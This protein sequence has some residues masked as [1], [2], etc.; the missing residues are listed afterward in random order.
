[1]AE[2]NWEDSILTGIT[3][4]NR[5]ITER[6]S[7]WL[8]EEGADVYSNYDLPLKLRPNGILGMVVMSM[9]EID[10]DVL[11]TSLNGHF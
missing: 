7:G 3:P 6:I 9:M 11:E 4:R 5:S 1:M 8:M 10:A 2:L